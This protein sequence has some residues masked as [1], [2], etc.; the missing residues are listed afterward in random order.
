MGRQKSQQTSRKLSR[1]RTDGRRTG[2]LF[3]VGTPIGSPDDLTLRARTILGL[4]SIVAAETPLATQSLLDHHGIAVTIT[5]YGRGDEE[6]IRILL[7]RLD[8]GHDIALVSDSGM[9]VIYDPGRLLIAAARAAGHS[10]KVIPGP[11]A[12]T[13][14]AA[15][16]GFNADR[17]VFAG[18]LPRSTR[19]L[20]RFISS[21]RDEP[22]AAV[23]F[24]PSSVLRRVLERIRRVLPDRK[25][26]VAVNMTKSDEQVYEGDAGTL[27][28]QTFAVAGNTEMTLVLSGKQERR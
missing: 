18:R 7:N 4:V 9:P 20:D 5:G 28:E 25:L 26:I 8:A 21:L 13:A 10:V 15:L 12:L 19:Q 23:M 3:I 27:L 6:K 14:A 11:S 1:S 17:L 2:T 16:S 24:T 22:G